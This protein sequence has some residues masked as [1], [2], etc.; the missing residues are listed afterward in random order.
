MKI[1]EIILEY[2]DPAKKQEYVVSTL[3]SK[4]IATAQ[5]N[6]EDQGNREEQGTDYAM[7]IVKRLTAAD[8]SPGGDFL[9]WIANMYV[10]KQF[11]LEDIQRLKTDLASFMK[12]R[13]KL[14][15][16]D[17]MS[18][19]SLDELYNAIE[20]MQQVDVRTQGEVTREIKN[21][22]VKK[23]INTPNFKAFIPTT[24]EAACFYGKGTKWCT[25]ADE[26]NQFDNYNSK[27]PLIMIFAKGPDGT[28]QKYQM[29]FDS[30]QFMDARDVTVTSKDIKFL[31]TFPQYK[32]LLNMLIDKHYA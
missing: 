28:D 21:D 23:I 10:K 7:D 3:G 25:S 4:I 24:K 18:Y 17:I 15:N 13:P 5:E 9:V 11:R 26:N 20:S 27:G 32:D 30:D 1:S 22:G 14:Q 6:H 29:Q 12:V 19:K 8:P 31:S 16:R 2:A